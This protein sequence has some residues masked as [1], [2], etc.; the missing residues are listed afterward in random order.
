MQ[1]LC[2]AAGEYIQLQDPLSAA[3]HVLF[4]W[5]ALL[6]RSQCSKPTMRRHNSYR[7]LLSFSYS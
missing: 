5:L 6:L 2:I 7:S 4:I 3:Y 1:W